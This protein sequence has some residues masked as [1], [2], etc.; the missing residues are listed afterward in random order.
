M[1]SY[2]IWNKINNFKIPEALKGLDL[3]KSVVK[4]DKFKKNLNSGDKI[5]P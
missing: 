5:V 4:K 3:K 1:K 2:K